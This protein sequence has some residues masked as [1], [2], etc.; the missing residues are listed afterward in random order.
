MGSFLNMLI[1]RLNDKR[2]PRFWQGRSV[3]PRCRH[4]LSWQDN[5]PLLSFVFLQGSCRYCHEKIS[6]QYPSVELL[7]AAVTVAV[8]HFWGG[9][10]LVAAGLYSLIAYCF[11][12]IFFSD[13][14]Y[15]LIPDE[16]IVVGSGLSLIGLIGRAGF[17]WPNLVVGGVTAG[18]FMLVV[19]LT[20]FR[21]MGLGDVKLA[22]LMGLLLG[23]PRVLVAV[24][25]AFILGGLV[26]LGLLSLR[27]TRL[28]A[29]MALGPFL[30][31]GV[32]IAALWSGQILS[33]LGRGALFG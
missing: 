2:A 7:T 23:W 20:K 33:V 28:S 3:C 11:I 13:L 16:M 22:F 27:K 6:W 31:I 24:G 18:A 12:V 9:E 8:W 1:W 29:T 4:E 17:V 30:V 25:T 10:S 5:I 26:A 19:L 32:L 21:G 14:I 15:G